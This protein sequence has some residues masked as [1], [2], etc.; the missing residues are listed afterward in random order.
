MKIK[1]SSKYVNHFTSAAVGVNK[2]RS[3]FYRPSKHSTTFD[4]GSIVPIY[5]DEVLPGSSRKIDISSVVRGSTPKY[6]VMDN[7]Y[8]DITAFFVPYRLVM[9]E[10]EQFMG[11]NK[12]DFW[13][14]ER[15]FLM[16][17]INVKSDRYDDG[18]GAMWAIHTPADYMGMF[19]KM[20]STL[21]D[22][23]NPTNYK[24]YSVGI[25]SWNALYPRAYC[26]IWNDWFR[27]Q[28]TQDPCHIFTDSVSRTYQ[29]TDIAGYPNSVNTNYV[30]TAEFGLCTLRVNKFKDYFTSALPAPQ[31][32]APITLPLGD[33]AEVYPYAITNNTQLTVDKIAPLNF[34]DMNAN[35]ITSK[36]MVV[37]GGTGAQAGTVDYSGSNTLIN[38]LYISR[39]YADLS[40]AT[41]VT[42]NQLR[43]AFQTQK[44]YETQAR[45]GSRYTEII[46]SMFGAY[47]ADSRLQR[48]EFLGGK[49]VPI[50]QTQVSQTAQSNNVGLGSTGAF[51]LTSDSSF[52]FEKGFTEHGVLMILAYVRTDHT[53]S[54]GQEKMFARK[55][56]FDYYFPVFS[57]IGEQPIHI[58]ELYYTGFDDGAFGDDNA[59]FGYQEAWAEYRYKPNRVSGRFRPEVRGSLAS[60]NYAD[61]YDNPPLLNSEY[62]FET[63]DN[64]KRSLQVTDDIQWLGDF[65]FKEYKTEVMPVY[66]VPGLVDH[67]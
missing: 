47:S 63:R 51:S 4:T 56:L 32:H 21:I 37:S 62:T 18:S 38:P 36:D 14:N 53:Y 45:G 52:L 31:K 60:W 61:D 8:L 44:F 3:K 27:N 43:L 2:P 46:Y 59:V 55:E 1:N 13:A 26:K 5:V 64:V 66:S 30:D 12:D 6:P 40:T 33:T 28:N 58:K 35:K 24:R 11:E 54:Q 10:F 34:Y 25:R 29:M 49:R 7:A 22:P 17:F 48:A 39:G 67:F 15:E 65:M 19:G 9:D 20:E 16:P 23:D 57:N 41:A 42:V 50:H